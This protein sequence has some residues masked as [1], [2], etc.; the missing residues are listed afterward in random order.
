M[1]V[2]VATVIVLLAG[3]LLYFRGMERDLADAI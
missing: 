1:L 2:S 3:G